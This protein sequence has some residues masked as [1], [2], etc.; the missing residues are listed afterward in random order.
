M[1]TIFAER[2]VE[3]RPIIYDREM[4]FEHLAIT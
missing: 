1:R 4:F 3:R 2:N